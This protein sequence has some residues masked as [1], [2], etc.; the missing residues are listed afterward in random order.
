LYFE[1]N[2]VADHATM[3]NRM[4]CSKSQTRG[5]NY[6]LFGLLTPSEDEQD[7]RPVEVQL[8][9][10]AAVRC[11]ELDNDLVQATF[12]EAMAHRCEG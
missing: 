1:N 12:P 7:W 9:E 4:A 8:S 6:L 3:T 11:S 10:I 5:A 2:P